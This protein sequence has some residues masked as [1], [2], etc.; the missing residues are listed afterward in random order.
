MIP[1]IN[2]EFGSP[3]PA[4]DR[5]QFAPNLRPLREMVVGDLGDTLEV[6]RAAQ[7]G[8]IESVEL[9]HQVIQLWVRHTSLV[10]QPCGTGNQHS[11][12]PV[13]DVSLEACAGFSG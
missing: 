3:G 7:S 2:A 1:L 4:F 12:L 13:T 11:L 6:E 5:M 8:E 10:S 9:G